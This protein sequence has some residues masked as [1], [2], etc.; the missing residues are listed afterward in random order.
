MGLDISH[1]AWH[2]GYISF[3]IWRQKIA[4]VLGIPLPFMEGYYEFSQTWGLFDIDKETEE[5][6]LPI[7]WESLKAGS[8]VINDFL[9]HSDSEG[10]ISWEDAGLLANA[11]KREVLPK[12]P[13]KEAPGHIGNW[14][15][16]TQKFIDGCERAWKKKENLIFG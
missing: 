3:M 7:K 9:R 8:G 10:E 5:R 11:F 4:E 6:F 1:D 2:G 13:D 12:M 14:K 15:E 16:K